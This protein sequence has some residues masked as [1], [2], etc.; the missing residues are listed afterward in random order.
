MLSMTFT[1]KNNKINGLLPSHKGSNPKKSVD[2][3]KG[4]EEIHHGPNIHQSNKYRTKREIS[5]K[6]KKSTWSN[7]DKDRGRETDTDINIV[8]S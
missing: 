4:K 7:K 2:R 6:M 5:M 8:L 1:S 3:N